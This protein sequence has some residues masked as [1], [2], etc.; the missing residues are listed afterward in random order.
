MA[1][2]CGCSLEEYSKQMKLTQEVLVEIIE[3]E[4]M[5]EDKKRIPAFIKADQDWMSSFEMDESKY[6]FTCKISKP[7]EDVKHWN[8]VAWFAEVFAENTKTNKTI[9]LEC[10]FFLGV[11]DFYL[12]NPAFT[13]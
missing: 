5:E 3:E 1:K 12:R 2:K 13:G 10:E 8:R 4:K 7:S 6:T 9:N 11:E